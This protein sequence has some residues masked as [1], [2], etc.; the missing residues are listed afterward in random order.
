MRYELEFVILQEQYLINNTSLE[1]H[2]HDQLLVNPGVYLRIKNLLIKKLG[3][4]QSR[5]DCCA[6]CC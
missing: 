6:P 3:L 4:F 5:N 1:T 2:K